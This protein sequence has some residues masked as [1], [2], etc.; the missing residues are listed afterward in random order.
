MS[1]DRTQAPT[2]RRRLLARE[3]GQAARSGEL[4]AAAGLLAASAALSVCGG[5]L[6]S[7]LL[8]LVGEPLSA[9]LPVSAEASEVVARVRHAAVGVA[10]PVLAVVGASAA[11][12]FAAHQA[13]V[14]GL[15]A[16]GLLAPDPA[17]LWA[18]GQGGGLVERA[19]RGL[20]SVAKAAV[21]VVV[22]AWVVSSGWEEFS[23]LS[24]L[25][26]PELAAA[27]GRALTR[28]A[29]V[30][31]AATLALGLVDFGLQ[32]Q[33]LETML[34]L[35]PDEQRE[36]VRSME[37]D[38]ALR[39]RRRRIARS[40]RGGHDEILAGASLILTGASGLTVVLG[41]GPPPRRVS[42]RSI[43]T[44]PAGERLRRDADAAHYPRVEAHDLARRLARRR[45]PGLPPTAALVE[46]I[47]AAWGA[48]GRV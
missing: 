32:W 26:T 36:E 3:G 1:E 17:R 24:A 44:G 8:G 33:R 4:S 25:D 37:G 41:G 28:L 9:A 35:T 42:I 47:A 45:P 19:G 30:L 13:Q 6:A 27:C 7:A 22:A 21:V 43:L 40:W 38:P 11:G 48:L 2:A 10:G 29:L 39:A 14:R 20:W 18:A 12:A 34:R 15:W 31:A 5:S 23:R 46:E 16:P